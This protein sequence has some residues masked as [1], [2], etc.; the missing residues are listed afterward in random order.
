MPSLQVASGSPGWIFAPPYQPS[1]PRAVP[2]EREK[3]LSL[4]C[5]LFDPDPPAASSLVKFVSTLCFSAC[6]FEVEQGGQKRTVQHLHPPFPPPAS[7]QSFR[8]LGSPRATIQSRVCNGND[9][10]VL[11]RCI[12]GSRSWA[13]RYPYFVLFYQFR[14]QHSEHRTTV[15]SGSGPWFPFPYAPPMFS[16]SHLTSLW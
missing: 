4:P 14:T 15:F 7:N 10:K 9:V 13:I 8:E 1:E 2:R 16:F 11:G 5:S 12:F 6:V 3:E